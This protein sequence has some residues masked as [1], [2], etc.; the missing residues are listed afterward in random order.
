M[1]RSLRFRVF[2][3]LVLAGFSVFFAAQFATAQQYDPKLYSEMRWRCIRPFRGG[4][5]GGHQWRSPSAQCVLHGCRQRRRL[6][7]HRF[8]QYLDADL[9]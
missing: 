7:D 2:G 5:T 1:N 8:R 4:R 9:R 3:S 6:G